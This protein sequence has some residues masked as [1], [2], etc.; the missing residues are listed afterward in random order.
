MSD[1]DK[2]KI[3]PPS[4]LTLISNTLVT[5]D[6][7]IN[8]ESTS[9]I[10]YSKY[11]GAISGISK[12]T[13]SKLKNN[14]DIMELFPDIELAT[15]ILVSTIASPKDMLTNS[16][17]LSYKGTLIPA[18]I[19]TVIN[20]EISTYM[21]KTYNLEENLYTVVEKALVTEGAYAEI[22]I[23]SK[24]L[25]TMASFDGDLESY[26]D[27]YDN[28]EDTSLLT[29]SD[30]LELLCAKDTVVSEMD[31]ESLY[32]LNGVED[33]SKN[34]FKKL[35]RV[36]KP[37]IVIEDYQDSALLRKV[38]P[39]TSIVPLASKD[40]PSKHY[41]YF[42]L[43]DADG[44]FINI[45]EQQGPTSFINMDATKQ[46]AAVVQALSGR[47]SMRD[48]SNTMLN[49]ESMIDNIIT[50]SITA[51]FDNSN[52]ALVNDFDFSQ[53]VYDVMFKR[54]VSNQ[55]TRLVFL[56]A[57]LVT[58]FA[59]NYRKDGTG[60]SLLEKLAPLASL[61]ATMLLTRTNASI[62]NSITKVK[63]ELKLDDTDPNPDKTSEMVREELIKS[64]M[65]A[66]IVGMLN[67]DDL[68]Q[69]IHNSGIYMEVEHESLP[70]M[71][72]DF[73]DISSD[74][75]EPDTDLYDSL[76]EDT[77]K[78]FG[79]SP[80]LVEKGYDSDFAISA[81]M[82]SALFARR[83]MM[84]KTKLDPVVTKYYK[85]V[86]RFDI[87]LSTIIKNIIM[88]NLPDIKSTFSN[89]F[90]TIV[91]KD[92]V[93]DK[94]LV[95]YLFLEYGEDMVAK[96]SKVT[97]DE[98]NGLAKAFSIYKTEV[99]DYVETYI[100][101]DALPEEL[102]TAF[103][104]KIDYVKSA[105]QHTLL[106]KWMMENNYLTDLAKMF[107]IDEGGSAT[108]DILG[109]YNAY[110][111]NMVDALKKFNKTNKKVKHKAEKKLSDGGDDDEPEPNVEEDGG[112]ED[113]PKSTTEEGDGVTSDENLE[114]M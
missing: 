107:T 108:I 20:D 47:V 72:L 99:G 100:S 34:L 12:N 2:G 77:A 19:A 21:S 26:V 98:D 51:H 50:N 67:I 88:T 114:E 31:T 64:K 28:V 62:E 83:V 96:T 30:N 54:I 17:N 55:K 37:S 10:D 105:I 89:E 57:H 70:N 111:N 7:G 25:E 49:A 18:N 45:R 69:H 1:K 104:G 44:S 109:E 97:L 94:Q 86:S 68:T 29:I 65:G 73:S 36:N 9:E 103:D 43:L 71:K 95:E 35:K 15:M 3:V 75:K 106:R 13:A 38:V 8:N 48:N 14:T 90:K 113:E 74:K 110:I 11:I 22:F 78:V 33:K 91:K 23:P 53:N 61:R 93:T 4:T 82:N 58:Y 24:N 5:K 66:N 32:D 46:S 39:T 112:V 85:I 79:L 42:I 81:A 16:I 27:E 87:K 52:K 60:K 6:D 40:D 92:K 101:E 41:G 80:E 84:F 102:F 76:K 59:F 56:P 63:V